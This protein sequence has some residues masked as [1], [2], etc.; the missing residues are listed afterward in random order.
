MTTVRSKA[1]MQQARIT[2]RAV[3]MNHTEETMSFDQ[4]CWWM[5]TGR[6]SIT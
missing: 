2:A 5:E 1:V 3:T 6:V 4:M